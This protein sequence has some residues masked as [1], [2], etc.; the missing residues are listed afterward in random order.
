VVSSLGGIKGALYV[1]TAGGESCSQTVLI[2]RCTLPRSSS[3]T[4]AIHFPSL[5][6]LTS[7]PHRIPPSRWNINNDIIIRVPPTSRIFR[8]GRPLPPSAILPEPRIPLKL[9]CR[10]GYT[11]I[12]N[13]RPSRKVWNGGRGLCEIGEMVRGGGSYE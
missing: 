8:L 9:L 4:Y 1:E 6:S 5:T 11:A 10:K 3:T 7:Y 12:H 2:S 13:Q